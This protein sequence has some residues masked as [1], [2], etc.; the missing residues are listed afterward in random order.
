[1]G[2]WKESL[3]KFISSKSSRTMTLLATS[4]TS[5]KT[6]GSTITGMRSCTRELQALSWRWRSSL[7]W[8]TTR[9]WDT[10]LLIKL[11]PDQRAWSTSW[12]TSRWR[13]ERRAEGFDLERWRETACLPMEL[14]T[15]WMIGYSKALITLKDIS[16][17]LVV[18]SS[19]HTWIA[20]SLKISLASIQ[21][22]SFIF[23]RDLF[24]EFAKKKEMSEK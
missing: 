21:K 7:G 1:M 19:Q 4:G 10:W 8:C 16:A 15:V 17:R 5:W 2:L 11:R 22:T 12:P 18:L 3:R 24:A 20:K 23:L 6:M 14:H 9:D 13:A